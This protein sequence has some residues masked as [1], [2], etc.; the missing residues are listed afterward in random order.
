VI[1]VFKDKNSKISTGNAFLKS[2]IAVLGQIFA[3]YKIKMH[4]KEQ[5]TN[6]VDLIV[7]ISAFII[8]DNCKEVLPV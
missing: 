6:C 2:K 8:V 4:P 7:N 1:I 3:Y 5:S